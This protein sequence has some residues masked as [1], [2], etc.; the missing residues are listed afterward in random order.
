MK[1]GAGQVMLAVCGIGLWGAVAMVQAVEPVAPRVALIATTL[2]ADS[3]KY[4]D[5]AVAELT[6]R[7][8]VELVER[9]AIRAVL[10]EQALALQQ[11]A[12]GVAVGKLLRADVVGVLETT[13]DG[14]EA[15]GF[16]VLDTATGVSY[17]NQGL[18]SSSVDAV[19]GEIVKGLAA[20]LEKRKNAGNLS[21]VCMLGA[22]NAEFPRNMD[23]FCETVAYLLDRRLVGNPSVMTLDRRRLESVISENNLPGVED[24]GDALL[25]SLRLV[26][27]DFRRGTAED[28]VKV[29]ARVTNAG[30]GVVAQP[31]VTGSQDAVV[32]VER[33]QAALA[34]TLHA[35]P[36]TATGDRSAEATRFRVQGKIL[37]DRDLHEAGMLAYDAAYALDPGSEKQIL[38]YVDRL[39]HRAYDYSLEAKYELAMEFIDR[40]FDIEEGHGVPHANMP[41]THH[42]FTLTTLARCKNGIPDGTATRDEFDRLRRRYLAVTGMTDAAGNP[43]ATDINVGGSTLTDAGAVPVYYPEKYARRLRFPVHAALVLSRDAD[44][45]FRLMEA[46]LAPWLARESDPQQPHDAGIITTLDHLRGTKMRNVWESNGYIPYDETYV[47]GLLN[48]AARMRAH[49]RVVVQLEGGYF[50]AWIEQEEADRKGEALKP[51]DIRRR[52]VTLIEEAVVAARSAERLPPGDLEVVYEMAARAAKLI[53]PRFVPRAGGTPC[54]EELLKIA[55]AMFDQRHLSGVVLKTLLNSQADF[56]TYRLPVLQRLDAARDDSGFVWLGFKRGE[57]EHMLRVLPQDEPSRGDTVGSRLLWA[58]DVPPSRW[59]RWISLSLHAEDGWY[60]VSGHQPGFVRNDGAVLTVWRID[61][62]TGKKESLGQIRPQTCWASQ[63]YNARQPRGCEGDYIEGAVTVGG[64][65]WIAT[66][67]DG[68]FGVPLEGGGEPVHIGMAEGLP[69][70]VVH[71]VAAA[72]DGLY[73]ACG[74][75]GTEGY[76]VEYDLAQKHCTVLASTMRAS[77]ETPLDSLPGGFRIPGIVPDE[78]RGRLLLIVDHGDLKP[79]TGIWECRLDDGSIRQLQQ[80]D[81]AAHAVLSGGDGTIWIYPFC[82]NPYRP[83]TERGG[84]YGAVQW[85]SAAD[86]ARLVFATKKKG[87][88]PGLPVQADTL[89][90]PNLLLGGALVAEGWLY[91]FAEK[92]VAGESVKEV[93]KVSLASGDVELINAGVFRGNEYQWGRLHWLPGKRIMLVGDGDRLAAVKIED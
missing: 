65:L 57:A 87:A 53:D 4:L 67:G 50:K 19:A 18:E 63:Y 14:K 71:T 92:Q 66:S 38:E 16:A 17:W 25:P 51:E 36:T 90:F 76:L 74:Q 10:G 8:G 72:E 69:S 39:L 70:D 12:S 1:P 21:T 60:A 29:L 86:T 82:R 52:A 59:D 20:A 24:K 83:I 73:V 44:E 46:R 15:G 89:I 79:A 27:L 64:R 34:G 35:A 43:S 88:G 37:W 11:D 33:L 22:R 3:E 31:E 49:P 28:E 32:L 81:R 93:R 62:E 77:P 23:V 30:G 55:E 80:M 78:A 75:Y 68:L 91:H 13:P 9:Q 42:D 48:M 40:G 2:N 58:T 6:A 47:N 7:G 61:V 26:E 41:G 45:F 85:D 5:V 84:W 56:T 54:D